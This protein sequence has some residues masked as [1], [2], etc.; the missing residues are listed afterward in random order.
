MARFYHGSEKLRSKKLLLNAA[1]FFVMLALFFS[2]ISQLSSSNDRRALATLETAVSRDITRCY[3]TEGAYPA[4]LQYLKDNYGLTYDEDRFFV[5]YQVLGA[6][7][8]PSVTIID[9]KA[10]APDALR[11]GKEAL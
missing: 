6:N 3:A 7:I 2:G 4:D 5:D 1:V 9:K 8:L 10:D 11:S